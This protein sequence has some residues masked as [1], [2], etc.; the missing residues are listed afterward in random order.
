M[1]D[2]ASNYWWVLLLRGL[3]AI[4]FGIGALVWPGL[5]GRST[6][7]GDHHRDLLDCLGCRSGDDL[8]QV[9]GHKVDR[10]AGPASRLNP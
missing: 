1:L 4:G 6:S 3:L 8:V 10:P 9:E 7:S 5:V 2:V